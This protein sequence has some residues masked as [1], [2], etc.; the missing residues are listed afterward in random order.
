[1][2]RFSLGG[3]YRCRCGW[4]GPLHQPQGLEGVVIQTLLGEEA[5]RGVEQQQ[6]L[7]HKQREG[8]PECVKHQPRHS[9]E[10]VNRAKRWT[11]LT[12]DL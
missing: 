8:A 7:P 9:T 12:F 1:M 6:V 4:A 3:A 5:F 10:A 11:N 2:V